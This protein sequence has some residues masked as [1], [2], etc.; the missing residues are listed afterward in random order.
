MNLTASGKED[1]PTLLDFSVRHQ[2]GDTDET[3]RA[4]WI[5][6]A[7]VD[8]PSQK[9]TLTL[10]A[11]GPAL[12]ADADGWYKIETADLNNIYAKGPANLGDAEVRFGV[13]YT[14][15]DAPADG[16][17]PM[18]T[19]QFDGDYTLKLAPVTDET[20]SSVATIAEGTGTMTVNGTTG[21]TITKVGG[22]S[23]A[24]FS[25]DVKVDQKAD[26]KAGGVADTDGSEKLSYLIVDNV[27]HGVSIKGGFSA[28]IGRASCRERV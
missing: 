13:K 11:T 7:D 17:L 16:T 22:N 6:A 24:T 27:P 20:S 8:N 4:V 18:A 19:K 23:Q 2:N 15:G 25:V 1:D 3:I 9:V 26:P 28:K 14:V 10:G 5:K 21:L 12:A